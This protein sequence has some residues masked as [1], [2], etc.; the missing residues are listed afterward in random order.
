[1]CGIAGAWAPRPEDPGVL[2]ALGAAM[3]G[4]ESA[5]FGAGLAG[6]ALWM[7][8]FDIAIRTIRAH[9]QVRFFAAA[10]LIESLNH[11]G[12]PDLVCHPAVIKPA[13][14]VPVI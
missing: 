3:G 4:A 2:H 13:A 14:F 8:R 7:L 9:G 11:I 10:M 12:H 6:M 1:M 5:L